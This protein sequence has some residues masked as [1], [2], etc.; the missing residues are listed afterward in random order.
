[1]RNG[2]ES[3]IAGRGVDAPSSVSTEDRERLAA[4]G[5][6][7]SATVA[8]A[9]SGLTLPD[10]KDKADINHAFVLAARAIGNLEFVDAAARLKWITDREPGMSDAWNQYAQVLIRLGRDADALNA[11]KQMLQQRPD[12]PSVLSTPPRC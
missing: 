12:Q 6:I 4:L 1:M 11:Y 2:L 3:L 5:Y 8:A 9:T 7:G 10:P